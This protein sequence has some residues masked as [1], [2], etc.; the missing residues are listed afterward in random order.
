MENF[1]KEK[2]I[3]HLIQKCTG[4]GLSEADYSFNSCKQVAWQSKLDYDI[5]FL[6][7]DARVKTV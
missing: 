1:I 7:I 2:D 6:L 4:G 3:I 5:L